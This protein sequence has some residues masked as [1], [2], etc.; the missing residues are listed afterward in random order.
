MASLSTPCR[1][2]FWR[3]WRQGAWKSFPT[4]KCAGSRPATRFRQCRQTRRSAAFRH[5]NSNTSLILGEIAVVKIIRRVQAGRHP[6]TE[7]TRYLTENSYANSP[8]LFGEMVRVDGDGT[9]Q[10]LIIAERFVR[11]QGDAWQWT[12][13]RVRLAIHAGAFAGTED[14]VGREAIATYQSF[15]AVM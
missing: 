11:N 9:P 13:D 10:T 4:A 15:A 8:A 5:S 3:A 12:L 6:Q 14:E 2:R 1:P 7:M